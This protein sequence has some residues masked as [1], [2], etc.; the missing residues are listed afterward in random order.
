MYPLIDPLKMSRLD[1]QA[2]W[3]RHYPSRTLGKSACLGCPNRSD[4]EWA[5]M[6]RDAPDDWAQV[7]EF[8]QAIRHS[9]G[10]RGK[11]YLHRSLRPLDA[12]PLGEGQSTLD[13]E[14]EIYCA[15]GCGL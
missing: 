2:W 13:L 11:S 10:M 3:D 9:I 12:V 15:G 8:D 14:D 7:V 5:A 4:R 1:C 6:K